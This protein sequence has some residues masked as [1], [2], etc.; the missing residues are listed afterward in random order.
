MV[1]TGRPHCCAWSHPTDLC[2][3]AQKRRESAG[4]L[5]TDLKFSACQKFIGS[6]VKP[7]IQPHLTVHPSPGV[8]NASSTASGHTTNDSQLLLHDPKPA[9]HHTTVPPATAEHHPTVY[10]GSAPALLQL[11]AAAATAEVSTWMVVWSRLL[12]GTRTFKRP[13]GIGA[14]DLRAMTQ[15]LSSQGL[16]SGR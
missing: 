14:L 8:P 6:P 3:P 16:L 5:D 1:R 7:K 9:H 4:N 12:A 13:V 10:P 15:L 11:S 2:C